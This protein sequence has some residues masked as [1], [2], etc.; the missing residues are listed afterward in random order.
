MR[1]S[2]KDW[3]L[4]HNQQRFEIQMQE[5]LEFAWANKDNLD[6]KTPQTPRFKPN[7]PHKNNRN[8]LTTG[9]QN[10][11][12]KTN[13]PTGRKM[14]KTIN[15]HSLY[16]A[17]KKQS[18]AIKE[19]NRQQCFLRYTDAVPEMH[20]FFD[21]MDDAKSDLGFDG[22]E[23]LFNQV[24]V[25]EPTQELN[26]NRIQD[27]EY[28]GVEV[29][30]YRDA[31]TTTLTLNK[32]ILESRCY[33]KSNRGKVLTRFWPHNLDKVKSIYLCTSCGNYNPIEETEW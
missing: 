31:T 7:R 4:N 5:W 32:C 24:P 17:W 12:R 9:S 21:F 3:T 10:S 33:C 22:F 29:V 2:I 20:I 13:I 27:S 19:T 8:W 1:H 14:S 25:S 23:E 26:R 6:F 30:M 18:K 15:T 28:D 16:K 11:A